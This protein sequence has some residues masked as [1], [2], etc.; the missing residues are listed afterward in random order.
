MRI[1]RV[2]MQQFF[3][4]LISLVFCVSVIVSLTMNLSSLSSF[5]RCAIYNNPSLDQSLSHHNG[6]VTHDSQNCL[7]RSTLKGFQ[8]A[9]RG[10]IAILYSGTVRSFSLVFHSHLL[11]L[12]IPSP[13][14]VHIF[15]HASSGR[16]DWKTPS[17]EHP[18]T[19]IH[20]GFNATIEY[21]HAFNNIDNESVSLMND[22]V[23]YVEI[24]DDP[25]DM[26]ISAHFNYAEIFRLIGKRHD[27]ESKPTSVAGQLDSLRRA[28]QARLDYELTN[29]IKYQWIVRLRMDHLMKT[30]IW[31][32]LF[33]IEPINIS[34]PYHRTLLK[35]SFNG[36]PQS[37]TNLTDGY[38]NGGILYDMVYTPRKYSERSY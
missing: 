1:P 33:F 10:H 30:N 17:R 25:L 28:N 14:H 6:K 7:S 27:A 26:N 29:H 18:H 32:D 31:E 23:K 2:L 5:V 34:N 4:W 12:I 22:V 13:Y 24:S 15:M 19:E 35:Q 36:I 8:S 9:K 20:R 21:Y 37:S 11:N 16:H 38:W 3:L